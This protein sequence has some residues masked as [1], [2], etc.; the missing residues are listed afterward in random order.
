MRQNIDFTFVR[1]LERKI[2]INPNAAC[3]PKKWRT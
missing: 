3:G 1:W 2:Q